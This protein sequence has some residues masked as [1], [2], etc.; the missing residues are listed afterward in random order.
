MSENPYIDFLVTSDAKYGPRQPRAML[1]CVGVEKATM[2]IQVGKRNIK[3]VALR[4]GEMR[5][6]THT[7][8]SHSW[9]I[10]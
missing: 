2:V 6:S 8:C 9:Q 4:L 1:I 10:I 5:S 3:I 7:S